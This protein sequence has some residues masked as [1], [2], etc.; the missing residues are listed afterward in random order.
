MGQMS[1][2]MDEWLFYVQHKEKKVETRKKE[3]NQMKTKKTS[4]GYIAGNGSFKWY[5]CITWC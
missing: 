3:G 5:Q 2:Q 1:R 4:N